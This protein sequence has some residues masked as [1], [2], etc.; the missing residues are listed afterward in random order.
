MAAFK[1]LGSIGKAAGEPRLLLL[2]IFELMDKDMN[3]MISNEGKKE[4]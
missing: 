1:L 4:Q 2:R 3:G